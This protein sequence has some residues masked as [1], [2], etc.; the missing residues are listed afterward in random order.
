VL[1]GRDAG[2]AAGSARGARSPEERLRPEDVRTEE[3]A[4]V[5][6]GEAVV[7]LG[8]EVDDRV[9][10]LVAEDA[11][12]ELAVADVPLDEGEP[13]LD[14]FE[15][16]ANSLVLHQDQDDHHGGRGA[17]HPESDGAGA[18]RTSHSREA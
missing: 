13:F 5:D 16:R 3:T 17:I 8:R 4:W 2:E 7:R 12:C 1:A 11:L 14:V 18:A 6:D 9:D 10:L 15:A